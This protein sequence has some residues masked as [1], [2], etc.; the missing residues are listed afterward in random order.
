MTTHLVRYVF[1]AAFSLLP[2]RMDSLPARALILTI[3]LQESKCC[4]RLQMDGPARGFWQFEAG[5]G[6]TGVIGHLKTKALLKDAL[7]ALEYDD[8]SV[9]HL[10]AALEHNDTLAAVFARLLLLTD[11]ESLPQSDAPEKGW[12]IYLRTWRPGKPRP[13][14]WNSHYRM[15]WG[16]VEAT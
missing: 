3:A 12:A 4:C 13:E 2:P 11:P 7:V 14:T 9:S 8:W 6:V 15:A 5:G 10:H 1:P 16:A